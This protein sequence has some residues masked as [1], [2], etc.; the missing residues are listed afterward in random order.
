MKY[1]EFVKMELQG[2][3]HWWYQARRKLLTLGL[4]KYAS[5]S[6]P[7]KILDLASACG[8][9]LPVCST[10]GLAIGIDISPY[11]IR[12]C[13]E[14]DC[15]SIVQGDVQLLPFA[16]GVFDAVIAFDIF[17]HLQDDVAA[18]REAYRVLN[19]KGILLINVPAFMLLYSHHD[20]AFDHFRRYTAGEVTNK[21]YLAN[22]GPIYSSYWSFFI[23]PAVYAFRKL[24]AKRNQTD[25]RSDFHA[26]VPAWADIILRM[27][28]LLEIFLISKK[29]R[30]PFGVS[31]YCVAVKR[32][33]IHNK[34]QNRFMQ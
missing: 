25:M 34:I 31:L 21:L 19:P 12:F 13:K 6:R 16:E 29:L 14:K 4:N 28:S 32:G 33:W 23:F 7:L 15:D 26:A 17:E 9:S 5:S 18:M 11:S 27:F 8:G 1:E 10:Y 3:T 20:E 22:F 24:F 30:F 2:D